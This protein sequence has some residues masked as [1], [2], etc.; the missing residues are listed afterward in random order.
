M[1]DLNDLRLFVQIVDSG[2]IARASHALDLP[3]SSVS[4]RLARLERLL[5]L[6]LIERNAKSFKITESGREIYSHCVELAASARAAEDR[7][8]QHAREPS[9]RVR[10]SSSIAFGQ[11][12]LPGLLARFTQRFPNVRLA[13][14]I[15]NRSADSINAGFDV[16][17]R[18]HTWDLNDSTLVQRRIC[19]VPM[20]PVAS[21]SWL[22]RVGRPHTPQDLQRLDVLAFGF[23]DQGMIWELTREG[24]PTESVAIVPRVLIG[25]MVAL[26]SLILLQGGVAQLPDYLC[27]ADL[28]AGRLERVLPAWNGRDSIA[29]LL[30]PAR[31]GIAPGARA[32]ADF[33]AA[34]LPAALA[35]IGCGDDASGTDPR[36]GTARRRSPLPMR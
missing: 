1:L 35:Q 7:V 23:A 3:A 11:V 10:L 36:H 30:L 16:L 15:A 28:A 2:G 18:A 5:G 13:V 12:V 9:G 31:S 21:P 20:I 32:L 25:D 27:R 34:E 17:L 6:R 14:E 8:E 19:V 4:R 22:D 29:T 26:R 24:A 33:I